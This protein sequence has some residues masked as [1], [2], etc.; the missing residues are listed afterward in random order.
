MSWTHEII[1]KTQLHD[2]TKPTRYTMIHEQ[3]NLAHSV[4]SG[5]NT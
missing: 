4:K 3:R 1:T 2:S 5:G